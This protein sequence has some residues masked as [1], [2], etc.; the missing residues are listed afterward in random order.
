V[1]RAA[2]ADAVRKYDWSVVAGDI[3]SVYEM[4]TESTARV[5]AN[6]GGER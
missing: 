3:L 5:T 1:L 2:A 6:G 4:V